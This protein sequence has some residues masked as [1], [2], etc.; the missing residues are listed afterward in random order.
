[1]LEYLD[2]DQ[3]NERILCEMG[4]KNAEMLMT[5]KVKKLLKGETF[6]VF[7]EKN[8]TAFLILKGMVSSGKSLSFKNFLFLKKG[9]VLK[10][11]F[12]SIK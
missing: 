5:I 8:E 10:N 1:M 7:D 9:N 3:N 11:V 12:S 2:F 4:G 6:E